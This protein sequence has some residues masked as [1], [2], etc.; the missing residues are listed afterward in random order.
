MWT[1]TECWTDTFAKT[2]HWGS[3]KVTVGELGESTKVD[4]LA[5]ENRSLNRA[6]IEMIQRD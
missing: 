5:I 3:V 2:H 4:H 6:L 1:E